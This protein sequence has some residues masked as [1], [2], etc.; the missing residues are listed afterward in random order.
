MTARDANF[1]AELYC[2]L[3]GIVVCGRL[4][5]L[6]EFNLIRLEVG[7]QELSRNLSGLS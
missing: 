4:Q 6:Q 7:Q 1:N 3:N 2:K 5:S